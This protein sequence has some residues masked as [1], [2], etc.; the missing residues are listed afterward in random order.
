MHNLRP[1]IFRGKRLDNG[2]WIEGDLISNDGA[3]HPKI[4]FSKADGISYDT[5]PV[6]EDTVCQY[7]GSY[8]GIRIFEHDVIVFSKRIPCE[9][10]W[11]NTHSR[12]VLLEI[13]TQVPGTASLVTV[14]EKYPGNF[15][16]LGFI[17]DCIGNK[18]WNQKQ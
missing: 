12:F 3:S 1:V 7:V 18:S 10:I 16:N 4:K 2:E 5:K 15:E 9:V 6:R 8:R 17:G 11:D 13:M 14:F